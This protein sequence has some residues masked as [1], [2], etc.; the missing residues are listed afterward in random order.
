MSKM[1]LSTLEQISG[2]IFG[3]MFWHNYRHISIFRNMLPDICYCI[4][5]LL[6]YLNKTTYS[7][8]IVASSKHD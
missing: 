6:E 4:T 8:L 1:W 7:R 3:N 2:D 5:T